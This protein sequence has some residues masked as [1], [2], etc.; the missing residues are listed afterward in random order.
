MLESQKEREILANKQL[1]ADLIKQWL[2]K[3]KPT[4]SGFQERGRKRTDTEIKKSIAAINKRFEE[5]IQ[6]IVEQYHARNADTVR[7]RLE[8][9]YAPELADSST[10]DYGN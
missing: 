2:K 3:N 10:F 8:G 7:N 1:E 6:P 5:D 4:R 9:A